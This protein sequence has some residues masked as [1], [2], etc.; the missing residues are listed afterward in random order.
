VDVVR[1]FGERFRRTE[2]PQ[3][4]PLPQVFYF[5]HSLEEAPQ[6]RAALHAKCVVVDRQRVFVSSAN[7]TEAAQE[8][9]IEVGLLI[10]SG[11]LAERITGHFEA[12]VAERLLL[13]VYH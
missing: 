5:P 4:C 2:W 9:N 10:Q 13:P 11:W 1:R 8:R 3:G 12:M 6:Q 7:F